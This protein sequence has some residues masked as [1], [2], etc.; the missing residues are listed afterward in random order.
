MCSEFLGR[1]PERT[2]WL[3][4]I[5]STTK[6]QSAGLLQPALPLHLGESVADQTTEQQPSFQ[7]QMMLGRALRKTSPRGAQR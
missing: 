4:V 6:I 3:G 7:A 2:P 5:Y 1:W